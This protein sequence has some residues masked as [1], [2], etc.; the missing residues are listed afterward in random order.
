MLQ[1]ARQ[2]HNIHKLLQEPNY[3]NYPIAQRTPMLQLLQEP[4]HTNH[5]QGP[6]DPRSAGCGTLAV[7]CAH[8]CVLYILHGQP[9][10]NPK[11]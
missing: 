2:E 5:N 8:C 7:A 9:L 3:H 11:P 1:L 6:I 10:A 4:T